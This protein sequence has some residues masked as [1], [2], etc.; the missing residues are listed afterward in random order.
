[1]L[2][3]RSIRSKIIF[4]SSLCLLLLGVTIIAYATV[5]VRNL[6]IQRARDEIRYI[7]CDRA[8]HVRYEFDKAMASLHTLAVIMRK[9][10]DPLDPLIIEREQVDILL[11]SVIKQNK[12]ILG[13]YTCWLPDAFDNRVKFYENEPGYGKTGRF[14]PYWYRNNHGIIDVIPY[15]HLHTGDC[16]AYCLVPK[17]TKQPFVTDP[18]IHKIGGKDVMI[19]SLLMPIIFKE[20]YYGS[21]GIDIKAD[22]L[23]HLTEKNGIHTKEI[24]VTILTA[25]G[26]II[27]TTGRP[28]LIGK[29]ATAISENFGQDFKKIVKTEELENLSQDMVK[30]FI[31]IKIA[32]SSPWWVIDS[33]P[34][35]VITSEAA[36]L[37]KRLIFVGLG[38]IAISILVLWLFTFHIVRSLDLLVK[39][40]KKIK[41]GH[42]GEIVEDV[43][44]SDEIGKL[45]TAFNNM[46]IE[47]KKK[48]L[49]RNKIEKALKQSEQKFRTIFDYAGDAI[50]IH[51]L[52]G[53]FIDVNRE[54]YER[55]GYSKEELIQMTP[56]DLYTPEY[57][58]LVPKRIE[59]LQRQ[60]SSFFLTYHVRRD[61]TAIPS[62]VS[63][64]IVELCGKQVVLSI[65]RDISE[66][67]SDEEALREQ[68]AYLSSIFRA[69]P[70]GIGV[71]CDRVI[72]KVND[73]LCEMTGYLN[74]EL[75]GK[76]A[77]FLYPTD[78]DF[79]YVGREKYQQIRKQGTGTVETKWQRKDGKVIDVLLSSTPIDVENWSAG[80]TFTALDITR[81]KKTEHELQESELKYRA[82][83]EA[84]K[85]PVYICSADYRVEY[86]NPAMIKRT[87]RDATGEHC[88][89]AIHD[90]DK[91]CP[92]CEYNR[93]SEHEHFMSDIV[94]PK[95]NRSYHASHS[96]VVH[97]NGS[98]SKMT[99]LRDTTDYKTMETQLRQ[100]QKME[101]IG[102]LAG[103]I[104]HDFN[105]ILT[106]VS[107]YLEIMLDEV[108]KDNP[109]RTYLEEVFNG[110]KRAT[111]LVK[112][113]LSFSRQ[114]DHELHPLKIQLVIREALKL[115]TSSLPSTIEISQ[116]VKKDC[117]LVLADPT[118]IHQIVMNLCTNAFHSMEETGG[119]L[120]VSL[121]ETEL[122]AEDLENSALTPGA[123]VSLKV[124]DTGTGI[125]QGNM[126]RIFDPYFTTKEKGKGTGLG[127]AV[128]SGIVKSHGGKITV[129]S[130]VGK[131]T[132]F[133][134][135]FPT[136]KPQETAQENTIDAP[137]QKGT[138]RILWVDDE[139]MIV[140]MGREMLERL[141]Y[142]VTAQNGS[143]DALET[144]R[145]QP[146]KFDLVITDLTMPNLTGDK[147][148]VELMKI[149]SDIPVILCTGFSEKM[150]R[151]KAESLGIKKFLLK[152]V[153]RKDITKMIR[154]V[155][156]NK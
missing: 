151:E 42:Y 81:R 98:I 16:D 149:R 27:G 107:G 85:D 65:S 40:V 136:I 3:F 18:H 19:V 9:T 125:E 99:V 86:M 49:E 12:N 90:L 138:E 124:A 106:P 39:G 148:A 116:N 132:E 139:D 37:S 146:D 112:Q 154:D 75:R 122:T 70:T 128:I 35:N 80:I 121:N 120:T 131:G 101:S 1:M 127:L 105:N 38:C 62:E 73:R 104:A 97:A 48:E 34:D 92:W 13:A 147:L 66:R 31:P 129:E 5:Y 67:L 115:I 56:T 82:M 43:S 100:A 2:T 46:S 133:R 64:R 84:M 71:V 55:L 76:N 156:D 150:S 51:D 69:A 26:K 134:V 28:D 68:E 118:Q 61:G 59:E 144:F 91:K 4:C 145:A 63:S 152:P 88:F 109:L 6:A 54:V 111:A 45:A 36:S 108:S 141:G 33:L 60:G 25:S 155:L 83:M 137:A 30:F 117:G 94:S 114:S 50:V 102:T 72:Q 110:T 142:H 119:K 74:H 87:G 78:E 57:A 53:R 21:V 96:P 22:V 113:I 89:K 58:D 79:E 135:Y 14:A 29:D 7:A 17:K 126:E 140:E 24:R 143:V 153:I 41:L 130:E 32:G 23:Q 11:Q 123:F 77:K 15:R 103:G 10:K 8:E 47:I 93:I 20:Q 95:D 44:S 52:K